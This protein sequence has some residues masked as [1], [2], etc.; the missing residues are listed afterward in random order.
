MTLHAD[1]KPHA[2]R[3]HEVGTLK[4]GQGRDGLKDL[5]SPMKNCQSELLHLASG[6][7]KEQ[8]RA[9]SHFPLF[10]VLGAG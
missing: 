4:H 3:L 1:S 10:S 5:D 9:R 6:N 8:E 7:S 2:S